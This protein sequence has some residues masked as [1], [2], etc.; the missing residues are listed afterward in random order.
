MRSLIVVLLALAV[1]TATSTSTVPRRLAPALGAGADAA[2]LAALRAALAARAPPRM[3]AAG[4]VATLPR[5]ATA[6]LAAC[7][8]CG[9]VV[10]YRTIRYRIWVTERHVRY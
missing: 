3:F 9:C 8:S 5:V 6:C 7:H 1:A 2:K 4:H 10:R